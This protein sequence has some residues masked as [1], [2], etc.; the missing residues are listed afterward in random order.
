MPPAIIAGRASGSATR[1]NTARGEQPSV[2]A[3]STRCGLLSR[4]AGRASAYTYG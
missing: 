4:K 2:R 3:A 1:Q